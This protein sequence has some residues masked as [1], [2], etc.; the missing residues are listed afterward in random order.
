MSIAT[1][2]NVRPLK[3]KTGLQPANNLSTTKGFV[4]K[5]LKEKSRHA[6]KYE[7]EIF[8][9]HPF[10][11]CKKIHP[12]QQK[13]VRILIDSLQTDHN[14]E[15]IVIFGSSVSGKCHVDSD[16]DIYI[17][18]KENKRIRINVCDFL[19][20]VWTNFTVDNRMRKEIDEK[21]VTVY[22]RNTI[23]QSNQ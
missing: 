5:S 20:D 11:N 18:L 23:R 8:I 1:S 6:Q 16:V 21:G 14:V 19:Y 15:K 3:L 2:Y 12:M 4:K 13:K 22:E 10:L 7:W 17:T 9:N